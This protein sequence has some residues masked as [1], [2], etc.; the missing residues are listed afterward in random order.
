MPVGLSVIALGE[1][2]PALRGIVVRQRAKGELAFYHFIDDDTLEAMAS[3][4]LDDAV[5]I[6][7]PEG[8]TMPSLGEVDAL[9]DEMAALGKKRDTD[10]LESLDAIEEAHREMGIVARASALYKDRDR[11]D[12]LYS[13]WFPAPKSGEAPPKSANEDVHSVIVVL[14]TIAEVAS[15]VGGSP[16]A[17]KADAIDLLE[18]LLP[19][20]RLTPA[21]WDEIMQKHAAAIAPSLRALHA[22]IEPPIH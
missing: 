3:G 9:L 20:A 15:V 12:R 5:V 8:S 4:E 6:H 17:R 19:D 14:A 18:R 16:L 11:L 7:L 10:A 21:R 22:A 13:R 1:E 2:N